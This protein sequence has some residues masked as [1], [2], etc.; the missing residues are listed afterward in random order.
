[1]AKA[2]KRTKTPQI[3]GWYWFLPDE[4]H[5]TPTGQLRRDIPVILLVGVDKVTRDMPPARLVVRFGSAMIYVDNMSGDW[6]LI[7]AP[8]RMKNES[9]SRIMGKT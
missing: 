7:K 2:K 8:Q 9:L 4:N 5:L 3:V 6:E 1:M